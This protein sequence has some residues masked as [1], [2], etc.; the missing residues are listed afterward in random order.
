MDIRKASCRI[1]IQ[2]S[3]RAS[4][5]G[6]RGL[7]RL[8]LRHARLLVRPGVP[9]P[10]GPL[11]SARSCGLAVS[12]K[13]PFAPA[14]SGKRGRG[15]PPPG[16][17]PTPQP[18]AT[19]LPSAALLCLRVVVG[20]RAWWRTNESSGNRARCAR[21][22]VPQV[23]ALP[24]RLS[25]S[26]PRRASLGYTHDRTRQGASGDTTSAGECWCVSE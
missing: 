18:P 22:R 3:G 21:R 15:T 7:P 8:P 24:C 26:V 11:A 25:P 13:R 19:A 12:R 10:L 20:L 16:V 9:Y 17:T 23:L 1:A 6:P 5:Y 14:A 2:F 4:R